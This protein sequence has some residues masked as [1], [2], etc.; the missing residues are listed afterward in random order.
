MIDYL[1]LDKKYKIIEQVRFSQAC[2]T[3]YPTTIL[4]A[5]LPAQNFMEYKIKYYYYWSLSNTSIPPML[6]ESSV[7]DKRVKGW[8]K[9]LTKAEGDRNA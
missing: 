2:D 5:Q 9:L 3:R 7:T 8:N 1:G 4:T 6:W